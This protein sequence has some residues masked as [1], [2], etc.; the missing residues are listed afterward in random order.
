MFNLRELIHSWF[1]TDLMTNHNCI[2]LWSSSFVMNDHCISCRFLWMGFLWF[3][4]CHTTATCIDA[5]ILS[6]STGDESSLLL[7][8][9]NEFIKAIPLDRWFSW[10][11]ICFFPSND[12]SSPYRSLRSSYRLS[13][14]GLLKGLI[15]K[16]YKFCVRNDLWF[17]C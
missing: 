13:N 1:L 6:K 14:S 9:L 17:S 5:D 3:W 16:V 12:A 2:R 10:K 8:S 11:E 15:W 7:I 4:Y